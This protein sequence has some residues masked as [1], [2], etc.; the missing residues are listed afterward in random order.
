MDKVYSI[1]FHELALSEVIK[2]EM[3]IYF[4]SA[5]RIYEEVDCVYKEF[6]LSEMAIKKINDS[7]KE[8]YRIREEVKKCEQ[9]EIEIIDFMDGRYPNLL[10]EIPDP[11]MVIYVKG[12]VDILQRPLIG[13][14]GAR[15]CSEYGSEATSRVA[16]ELTEQGIIVV[17]GMA[18]GIDEAAHKGALEVGETV[19][20][21]GS[22][23]K[24]CYPACNYRIY[25]A[26]QKKG[27]LVSEYSIEREARP[28][29]FP[30]RN[31]IISGLS[32][33]VLVT[34]AAVRSGSLITANLALEYNR[35]VFAMPGN[36]TRKLSLGTNELIKKGAKCVTVA[37]DIIEELPKSIQRQLEDYKKNTLKNNHYELAQDESIV[38]AYVSWEPIFLNELING[39]QLSWEDIR[40]HLTT[41]ESKG[42]I[43]R[44]VGERYIRAR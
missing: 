32:L 35:D 39:T 20:V 5:K 16:K 22:G 19:A 29:Q 2:K 7:K 42:F 27:A 36:I 21:L 17:S 14:V 10:R 25:E 41:L 13:I 12:N 34:E 9:N 24:R 11:P 40:M 28:Y 8:V 18:M 37:S 43:K 6:G 15:K 38:Y 26:I 23:V 4:R 3:M 44:L 1:W 33:G 31:R 30:R